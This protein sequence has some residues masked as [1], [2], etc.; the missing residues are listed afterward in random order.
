ML[1]LSIKK[2]IPIKDIRKNII[3]FYKPLLNK[4]L[5]TARQIER[6]KN[7]DK[8]FY[9]H[10]QYRT[11]LMPCIYQEAGLLSQEDENYKTSK[12]KLR[13]GVAVHF[14]YMDCIC[15]IHE[16]YWFRETPPHE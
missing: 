3:R 6:E 10:M 11:R 5:H 14:H 2:K 13:R 16:N 4:I 1:I 8:W 7:Y 9:L 12:I 15:C